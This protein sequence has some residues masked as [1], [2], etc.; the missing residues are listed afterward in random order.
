MATDTI[1]TANEDVKDALIRHQ[2]YLL[3]FSAQVRNYITNLL[4]ATEQDIASKIRD[5]LKAV[6]G[7]NTPADVKRMQNLLQNV[8][9]LRQSAWTASETYLFDQ[10]KALAA[11]E[12]IFANGIYSTNS[13]VVIDL[14]LPSEVELIAAVDTQMIE[15]ATITNW[16]QSMASED[17]RRIV[18]AVQKGVVAGDSSSAIARSVLGTTTLDGRDGMTEI[19]R[20]QIESITRTIIQGVASASREEFFADNADVIDAELFVATLDSRTTAICRALDGKQFLVGEGPQPPLHFN[21]RSIR[22]AAFDGEQLGMRP[23]KASTRQGALDAFTEENDL[24]SVSSRDELPRGTKGQFDTFERKYVRELTGRV[25]ASTSYQEWLTTQ[26][27]AFQDEVL[28]KAKGKLFRD[29]GLTLDK[30]VAVSGSEL[31]LPQLAQKY[32]GAFQAAGLDP[33]KYIKS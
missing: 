11:A 30:Y 3:R 25:P 27:P 12:P 10:M 24:E 20:R 7:L 14:N 18:A 15:G 2:I 33:N 19:T 31:T 9:T 17:L 16:M 8:M 28:G 29:G 26:T 6:K 13:P 22:V 4:D 21:C 23:A 5:K 32:P 1:S